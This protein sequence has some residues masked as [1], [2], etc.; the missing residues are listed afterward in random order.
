VRIDLGHCADGP[1]LLAGLAEAL[2]LPGYAM[3]GAET[4]ADALAELRGHDARGLVVLLERSE[5][6][7][8]AAVADFKA[9]AEILQA[10]SL[11]WA[12]RGT[13]LWT[14]IAMAEGEFESLGETPA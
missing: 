2:H 3:D 8:R 1:A 4:F 5:A 7:R 12:A 13:P 14:F 11:R 9:V 10:A 6:L